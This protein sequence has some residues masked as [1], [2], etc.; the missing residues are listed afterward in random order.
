MI[1]LLVSVFIQPGKCGFFDVVKQDIQTS[2]PMYKLNLLKRKVMNCIT[3]MQR[4]KDKSLF[5]N[6]LQAIGY[7]EV[8]LFIPLFFSEIQSQNL[9]SN[10]H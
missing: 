1:R 3:F 8:K 7:K 9:F 5:Q 2:D 6:K 4:L 10:Q